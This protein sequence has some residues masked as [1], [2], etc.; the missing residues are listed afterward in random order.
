MKNTDFKSKKSSFAAPCAKCKRWTCACGVGTPI[1]ESREV[2]DPVSKEI[3]EGLVAKCLL[4]RDVPNTNQVLALI[5][6]K[7]KNTTL[8]EADREA[9]KA[10]AVEC[11]RTED[12]IRL[13]IA[14]ELS[15]V[16]MVGPEAVSAPGVLHI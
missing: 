3:V 8:S 1:P 11:Q 5:D 14:S 16:E 7:L 12:N 2:E 9:V 10:I 15:K 13:L 4:I 6:E